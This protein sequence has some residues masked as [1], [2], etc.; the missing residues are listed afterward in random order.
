M[1]N[2]NDLPLR[3]GEVADFHHLHR[4]NYKEVSGNLWVQGKP[5]RLLV[6]RKC[7][8]FDWSSVSPTYEKTGTN[9]CDWYNVKAHPGYLAPNDFSGSD[10]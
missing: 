9:E 1:N 7:W 8:W 2:L 4:G 3:E 10:G 6:L 5:R